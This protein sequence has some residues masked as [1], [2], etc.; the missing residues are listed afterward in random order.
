M[1]VWTL[2]LLYTLIKEVLGLKIH[3]LVCFYQD[4]S[5]FSLPENSLTQALIYDTV[6]ITLF[7]LPFSVFEKRL[8]ISLPQGSR[9]PGT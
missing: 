8:K 5:V 1:S 6:L 7:P 2:D 4:V 9:N 3:V